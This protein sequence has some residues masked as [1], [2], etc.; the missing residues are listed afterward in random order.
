[1]KASESEL[2]EEIDQI[3]KRVS[4]LERA[5]DAVLTKDDSEAIEEGRHDLAHGRTVPLSEV[6]KKHS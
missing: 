5:F 2:K 3:K 1:M 4:S 6:K